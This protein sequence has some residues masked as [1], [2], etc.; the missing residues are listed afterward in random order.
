MSAQ[1]QLSFIEELNSEIEWLHKATLKQA[2]KFYQELIHY[3][4]SERLNQ[5][6]VA[7]LGK[8]DRFFLL[9]HLLNRVDAIHP[10]VY[11]RCREVEASPDDHIDL[12]SRGHYKSTIITFAGSLQEIIKDPEITIGIFSHTRPIAKAFLRQIKL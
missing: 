4:V 3:P 9:T 11:G 12:W 5:F 10:W 6:I 2:I 7:E 8:W 1:P